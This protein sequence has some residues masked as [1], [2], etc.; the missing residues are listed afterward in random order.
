MRLNLETH[1]QRYFYRYLLTAHTSTDV[2]CIDIYTAMYI[3]TRVHSLPHRYLNIQTKQHIFYI[4]RSHFTFNEPVTAPNLFWYR[5][6]HCQDTKFALQQT[7][8]L[9]PVGPV[10]PAWHIPSNPGLCWAPHQYLLD[11]SLP[12]KDSKLKH[13]T[14]INGF[15]AAI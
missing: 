10:Q 13:N 12:P 7:T 2:V 15:F 9:C 14:S 4:L 3:Y 6:W 5:R 8:S 11:N 1:T